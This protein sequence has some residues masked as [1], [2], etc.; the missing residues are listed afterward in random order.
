MADL[1]SDNRSLLG[2]AAAEELRQL[3]AAEAGGKSPEWHLDAFMKAS[4]LQG[5][6]EAIAPAYILRILG[7]DVSP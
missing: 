7:L 1:H 2:C 6:R 4:T 5:Q 3:L